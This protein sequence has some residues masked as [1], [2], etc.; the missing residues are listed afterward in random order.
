MKHD[1]IITLRLVLR[2]LPQ[3]A[4]EATEA[5]HVA[6]AARSLAFDL[7]GKWKDV[8]PLARRRLPQLA[9]CPDYRPWSIRA[10]VLKETGQAI[11]Y[12]NFHDLPARHEM[13]Q[14]DACAEFGYTIFEEHRRKGYVE[15]AVRALM[16]WAR[17]RGARHFIFSIAPGNAASRGVAL[18]LGARKIG[19]QI[20]EE[21]GPEDV[22]LLE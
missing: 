11:G 17:R 6:E 18:K 3:D 2:L 15:E 7:P 10:I 13:A 5:G 20:D 8:A 22:F 9:E 16:D 21:D 14:R 19:V 4:L 1:D 12:V